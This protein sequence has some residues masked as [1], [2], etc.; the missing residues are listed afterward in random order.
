MAKFSDSPR[1]VL[2]LSR[3]NVMK[4]QS[5]RQTIVAVRFCFVTRAISPKACPA[6][7]ILI[8]VKSRYTKAMYSSKNTFSKS[9]FLD[10]SDEFDEAANNQES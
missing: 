9:E 4:S 10:S 7:I 5:S 3:V 8:A 1:V 6:D 2:K